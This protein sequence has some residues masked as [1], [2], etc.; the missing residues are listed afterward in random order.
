MIIQSAPRAKI[1]DISFTANRSDFK[2]AYE[3]LKKVNLK[4]GSEGVTYDDKVA[5]V[6][7]VGVGMMSHPGVAAKMFTALY[8]SGVN[9]DMI[10]TSEIK[11]SCA[12]NEKYAEKAVKTIHKA[13]L[14]GK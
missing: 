3:I 14:L 8:R 2:K 12:I 7:I 13:I 5:K 10:S 11:V 9:I 1:N 6:S 4:L